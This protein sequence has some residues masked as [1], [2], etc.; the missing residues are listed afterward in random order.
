MKF[1]EGVLQPEPTPSNMYETK[2]FN[3]AERNEI[4]KLYQR[5]MFL[6]RFSVEASISSDDGKDAEFINE[7][8]KDWEADKEEFLK[9]LRKAKESWLKESDIKERFGYMG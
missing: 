2:I 6:D 7:V 1:L 9:F 8:F 4:F 5:F 3:E